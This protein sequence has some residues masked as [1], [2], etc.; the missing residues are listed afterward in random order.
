MATSLPGSASA[1]G[2][3]HKDTRFLSDLRVLVDGQR[4]LLLSSD[5]RGQQCAAHGGSDQPRSFRGR[6][7]Q[8]SARHDPDCPLEV[9]LGWRVLRA[10]GRS[11]LRRRGAQSSSSCSTSRRISLIFS[12]FAAIRRKRRGKIEAR[13][14]ESGV[15]FLYHGLDDVIRRTTIRFDPAPAKIDE[16]SARFLVELGPREP[17]LHLHDGRV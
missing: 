2:V 14:D 6:Q 15:V 5:C 17:Q 4:P 8:A 3:F 7:T 11:Q 16:G 12:S 1:E 10:A 13:V 9:S